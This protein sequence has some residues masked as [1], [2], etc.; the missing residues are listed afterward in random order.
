MRNQ[1]AHV[2]D[3]ST[4]TASHTIYNN[5][6]NNFTHLLHAAN[7]PCER[8]TASFF[9][10]DTPFGHPRG[11]GINVFDLF[12]RFSGYG[13]EGSG[14]WGSRDPETG[15]ATAMTLP[16]RTDGEKSG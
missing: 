11:L 12:I 13:M 1:A 15:T 9:V 5:T 10:Y 14:L 6:L 3:T 4:H 8:M 7:H 16:E 2:N